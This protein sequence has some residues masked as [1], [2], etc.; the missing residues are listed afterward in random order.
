MEPEP[1]PEPR[2][3]A[4]ESAE[5]PLGEAPLAHQ[6]PPAVRG[7][8]ATLM[9]DG[10]DGAAPTYTEGK[11]YDSVQL[12]EDAKDVER[13]SILL[14]PALLSAAECEE[15]IED[16]DLRGVEGAKSGGGGF[17]RHSISGLSAS[18]RVLFEK[19]LR[20]RLLPFVAAELPAVE[21]YIWSRSGERPVELAPKQRTAGTPLGALPYRFTLNE[22]A[23]NRY[24]DG[25][26]FAPHTDQQA[27][28]L[29]ILLRAD[30]FE[31]GGTAFWKEC[32]PVALVRNSVHFCGFQSKN[33]EFT[34]LSCNFVR[35][36]SSNGR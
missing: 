15:L 33:V 10:R 19:V 14:V 32:D 20:E 27:L 8:W 30:V 16:V 24:S 26:E 1:E 21:D 13:N 5:A 3:P 34:P 35:K 2:P 25:G 22:P 17:E 4:P 7:R 12:G 28:T 6:A 9:V 36:S 18:T 11:R 29:N 23:I 31:G